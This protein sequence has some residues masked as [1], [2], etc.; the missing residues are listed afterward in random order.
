[1]IEEPPAFTPLDV[2]EKF[3]KLGSAD[4]IDLGDIGGKEGPKTAIAAADA[5]STNPTPHPG[6][7]VGYR[8]SLEEAVERGI[9]TL[10]AKGDYFG[11]QVSITINNA[12]SE[13]SFRPSISVNLEFYD[14]GADDDNVSSMTR[15]MTNYWGSLHTQNGQPIEFQLSTRASSEQT[16]P[17]GTPGFHQIRRSY[18]S[19]VN[20]WT[21]P[22]EPAGSGHWGGHGDSFYGRQ[23]GHLLGLPKR[24]EDYAKLQDGTWTIPGSQR[25]WTS[26]ELAEHLAEGEDPPPPPAAIEDAAAYLSDPKNTWHREVNSDDKYDL[27]AHEPGLLHHQGDVLQSDVNALMAGAGIIIEIRP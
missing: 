25:T 2:C 20:S 6:S 27:M 10:S 23:V 4:P 11:D 19:D 21:V 22:G 24:F 12:N 9:A 26:R 14:R 1:V 8:I 16:M 18:G 3:G 5:N 7:M 13:V 17:P 15:A